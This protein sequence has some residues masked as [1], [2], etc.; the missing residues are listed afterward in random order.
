[1]KTLMT[2]V[3]AAAVL[4]ASVPALAQTA[5]A[6]VVADTSARVMPTITSPSIGALEK[7]QPILITGCLEDISWCKISF[8][9]Q[10]AWV[11]GSIVSVV[12]GSNPVARLEDPTALTIATVVDEDATQ[13]EQ[14]AAAAFGA[15]VGSLIAYGAG[16]PAGAIVA[17]GILGT[18]ALVAAV[19]PTE[20][21]IVFVNANPVETV[22]LDG[23]VAVGA[24][25]PADVQT[26]AIPE[27]PDLRYLTVNGETVL[28]DAETGA[29]V[30]VVG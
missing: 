22:Y 18:S 8:G 17:G 29:I 10:S 12:P 19:E 21:T 5:D 14:N 13:R 23:E 24:G 2:G 27:Q 1:M 3:A 11:D 6:R 28:V 25:V 9:G 30:Y 26:F 7:D 15:T 16:G 20:E 4:A